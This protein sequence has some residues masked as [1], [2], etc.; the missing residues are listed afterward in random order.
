MSRCTA[1]VL[2]FILEMEQSSNQQLGKV[3]RKAKVGGVL[4]FIFIVNAYWQ[5]YLY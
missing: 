5:I 3:K 1:T 4:D 2:M